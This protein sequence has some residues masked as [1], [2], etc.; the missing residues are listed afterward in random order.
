MYSLTRAI[1]AIVSVGVLSLPGSAQIPA[2]TFDGRPTYKEG[3]ALGYFIWRDGDTWKLRWMT[4]G[5]EHRFN[6]RVVVEDGEIKSFKRVDVDEERKVIRPGHAPR[7]VRGPRGRVIGVTGGRA[8]VVAERDLDK[9]EQQ[10]ERTVMWLTKTNDD[11][12]GL[13]VK[14]SDSATGLRFFLMIDGK[15]VP[16]EVE[17]GKD[18]FKPNAIPIRVVLR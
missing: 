16:A 10:D 2:E 4:F 6:G 12:D 5:A 18:N 15:S 8:P 14:V 9:I 3:K 17:V 7:V 13:D 1:L 11:L